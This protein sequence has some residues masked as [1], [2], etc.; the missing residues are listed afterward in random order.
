VIHRGAPNQKPSGD[1][2][3]PSWRKDFTV[4]FPSEHDFAMLLFQ[5]FVLLCSA[6]ALGELFRRVGQPTVVG[7]I[8]AGI[9]LGPSFL[10]ALA[11]HLSASLFA[12]AQTQLLGSLAWLGSVFL[13][14]LAGMETNLA[15]LVRERRVVALTSLIG[16]AVPFTAGF[17]VGLNLPAAYVIDPSNRILFSLFLATALSISA[18]PLVAKILMDINLLRAPVGQTILGSAIV[19]DLVGWILFAVILSAA[20]I[21]TRAQLPLAEVI[22]LTLAFTAACLTVGRKLVWRL[23]VHFRTLKTP[24]E[25][26]LGLAVLIAFFC[27]ATTQW[28]G[29]HAIF[30]AFLAGVMIG[31]TGEAI[32]G[33]RDLLRQMVYY[34][35]SPIFFGT[36]GLRANFTEHF[37]LALALGL[38]AVAIVAKF[39]GGCLGAQLGGK[40]SRETVAIGLGLLPQGAMGII[41]AFLALEYGIIT[42]PVF[43]A[44]ICTATV[45]SLLSGPLIKRV[46]KP[47]VEP[48]AERAEISA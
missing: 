5:L 33:T 44:L 22:F 14:V 8:L 12:G 4:T 38:L 39:A 45:T 42:E 47:Q 35:F 29:I 43:V 23:F 2:S 32:N 40:K 34:I 24:P 20:A 19:N 27:A 21:N 13:L 17:I 41:L 1:K 46:M 28:I 37:D 6:L 15:T 30:G 31:E 48:A 3:N 25:G 9:L 11:P 10:G 7:E 18:I 26:I 16:I 36:M